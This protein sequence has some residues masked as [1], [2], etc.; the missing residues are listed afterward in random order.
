M[1]KYPKKGKQKK[2][3]MEMKTKMKMIKKAAAIVCVLAITLTSC[4]GDSTTDTRDGEVLDNPVITTEDVTIRNFD[5]PEIGEKIA[6]INVK[7]YGQIK[8]KLFSDVA[9]LG[10]ENF[11]GLSEMGYYDE[12]IF[13][14][15]I[16]NFV[17]QGG[18]PRGDGTGGNSFWGG[19]FDGGIPEGL[20][21]FSGA[22][23]YA[24]TGTT[25]TDGSQ[26]YIVDTAEGYNYCGGNADGTVNDDIDNSGLIMPGNVLEKYKEVGGV[27]MLDGNYT[28]FGQVF[29]GMDVV[30][31]IGSTETDANDKPLRQVVM[32]SIEIVEYAG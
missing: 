14:R 4:K 22:I 18:D 15:V 9:A 2:M 19:K 20:Y 1:K 28:V 16:E 5:M 7:D 6:V 13:H 30:R 23:A 32:E 21:H 3:K 11:I 31:A 25:D 8:V 26:F 17:I 27:P 24:S 29:E 10:T 12:L